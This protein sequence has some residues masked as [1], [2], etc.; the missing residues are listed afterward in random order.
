VECEFQDATG[1]THR[2]LEKAAIVTAD[3]IDSKT[4]YPYPGVVACRVIGGST[5]D[6]LSLTFLVDTEFPWHVAS[7]DEMT[8][9][10]VRVQDLVEWEFGKNDQKPWNGIA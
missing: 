3:D 9:F 8:H 5:R 10:R 4:V 7:T 6:P 2:F 1:R